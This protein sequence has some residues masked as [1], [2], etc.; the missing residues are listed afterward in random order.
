MDNTNVSNLEFIMVGLPD[1][2]RHLEENGLFKEAM[3]TINRALAGDKKLPT[4]LRS[5]LEWELERIKRM[6]W[7][8]GLSEEE[9]FNSLKE[10]ILELTRDEFNEWM[11]EGLIEHRK[12]EGETKVFRN[13]LPNLM[14]NRMEIRDRL[15][16]RKET[17]GIMNTVREHLDTVILRA[18]SSDLRYVEPVRNRILMTLKVKPDVVPEGETVKVWMPFSRRDPL[19]PIVKL[20][21]AVP[22]SQAIAPEDSPQ[23]TIYFEGKSVKGEGL[24]FKVEYEYVVNAMYQEID[25]REVSDYAQDK[26]YEKYIS[27][28]LPHIA[29]T[30]Y[31]RKLADEI[32]SGERNP[33]L[34]AWRI[35]EWI[36]KKV[37]YALVPEY[38]TID[39]ISD[40]AARNL[41]GDCGIQAL[42]FITLCRIS[43]IPAR[44][45]SGWFINPVRPSPHDWAQ[46]YVKPYGWL[47]ADPS[48][49][50]RWKNLEKY[51]KF[52]FG[53]IDHYRLVV[54]TDVSSDFVPPKTY[55]RSDT[56][57][58]QRGEVEWRGGNLYYDKW[59]YELKILSHECLGKA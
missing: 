12:I 56:V 8:Y 5:R 38:S 16:I 33:Y 59:T 21:S 28:L 40:Y 26:F 25:P 18:T 43:G 2:I 32:V 23:R 47:Y 50:G 52:Y 22:D 42:L 6:E 35:Y 9:A 51:H 58:N 13:F 19:Q 11:K 29:F 44:W 20:L 27:E 7:D 31:L 34:K 54:N 57:D 45:Q 53:N 30:P 36:T 1:D 4:A 41:R 55:L 3:S 17:E 49:G 46:F 48:F 24:E 39:C 37:S 15:K 10:C 14:S